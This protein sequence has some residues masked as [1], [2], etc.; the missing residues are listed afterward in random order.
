MKYKTE[1]H[2]HSKDVSGCSNES[3]EGIVEKYLA[4]GYRTV[5]LTNHFCPG[6]HDD[7]H[8]EEKVDKLFRGYEKLV[9]ASAGWLNIVMG[10]E[11]RFAENS[12]DYLVFGFDRQYLLDHPD[13]IKMGL[14]KYIGMARADGL[15]TIQ[16]HP[17]RYGM[18]VTRPDRLDGMEVFN[19]H[20]GHNSNNDIALHWAE[21][22]GLI[23]TS[24]TDHHNRDHRPDGGIITDF[25][26]RT[27]EE[28]I[29]ALRSGNYELIR[30]ADF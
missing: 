24:G 7:T 30:D 9:K 17:C 10:M 19:G 8:W 16:A 20:P 27:P 12:N 22:Y 15:F 29:G 6:S 25:P 2:C 21:K 1:L 28:L 14:G 11:L 23:Q 18:T 26:I 13:I 5:C 4:A 3:V